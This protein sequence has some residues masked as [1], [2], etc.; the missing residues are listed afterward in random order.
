MWVLV[1]WACSIGHMTK[2]ALHKSCVPPFSIIFVSTVMQVERRKEETDMY[3]ALC[4][5]LLD[6]YYGH[7]HYQKHLAHEEL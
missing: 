1:Q 5:A 7:R 3:K 6:K 2:G 4:I